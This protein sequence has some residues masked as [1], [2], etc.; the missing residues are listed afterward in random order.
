MTMQPIGPRPATSSPYWPTESST[1]NRA[2]LLAGVRAAVIALALL[3]VL[4]FIV[5][6]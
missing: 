5:L 4:V 2:Y 1:C 3:A 6:L